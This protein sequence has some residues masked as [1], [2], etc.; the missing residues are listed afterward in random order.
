MA[1]FLDLPFLSFWEKNLEKFL[2]KKISKHVDKDRRGIV[3]KRFAGS[4]ASSEEKRILKNTNRLQLALSFMFFLTFF[5]FCSSVQEKSNRQSLNVG[6]FLQFCS[7]ILDV[8]KWASDALLKRGAFL[9][10]CSACYWTCSSAWNEKS[11]ATFFCMSLVVCCIAR[12]WDYGSNTTPPE[13]RKTGRCVYKMVSASEFTSI[14]K[15]LVSLLRLFSPIL[16]TAPSFFLFK[17]L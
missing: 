6:Y 2:L 9:T 3:E 5:P 8:S 4:R 1:K 15:H 12:E 10:C 11:S 13:T 14:R 17:C 16:V 7:E